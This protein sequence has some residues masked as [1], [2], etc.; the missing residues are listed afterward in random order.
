MC[1]EGTACS[2][3]THPRKQFYL[4]VFQYHGCFI[5][6]PERNGSV[7]FTNN[8]CMTIEP[9]ERPLLPQMLYK[10]ITGWIKV[11]NTLQK[12]I[13]PLVKMIWNAVVRLQ[14]RPAQST[15]NNAKRTCSSSK[16]LMY[17]EQKY[18]N[19][20][21]KATTCNVIYIFRVQSKT[22]VFIL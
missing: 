4:S 19:Q 9:M 11:Q 13:K 18:T 22:L 2:L 21:R 1:R 6:N 7:S 15:I 8:S 12:N 10:L 17:P 3:N 5:E 14:D 16:K 20:L